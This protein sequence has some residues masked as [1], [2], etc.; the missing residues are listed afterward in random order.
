MLLLWVRVVAFT[1]KPENMRGMNKL[2]AQ[3]PHLQQALAALKSA[4]FNYSEQM[5]TTL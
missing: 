4:R 3:L 5:S 1:H 2:A